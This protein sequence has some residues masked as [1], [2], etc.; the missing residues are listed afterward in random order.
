MR[1]ATADA[2]REGGSR[3][4]RVASQQP[5]QQTTRVIREP[6]PRTAFAEN[7]AKCLGNRPGPYKREIPA[8]YDIYQ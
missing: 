1:S 5:A 7:V 8:I 4:G 3:R 6:H 2:S